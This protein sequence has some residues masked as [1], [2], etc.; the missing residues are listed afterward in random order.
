MAIL[1]S[2]RLDTIML[3]VLARLYQLMEALT[4][5]EESSPT[6]T[7]GK[8]TMT[9]VFQYEEYSETGGYTVTKTEDDILKE[10]W[11]YWYKQ[12]CQKYGKEYVDQNYCFDD[13]LL[14]WMIINWAWE[15]DAETTT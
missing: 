9:R 2:L 10:Y 5:C 1:S 13:C 11:P 12:M 3:P 7:T 6:L 8:N 14:D 15:I 4:T